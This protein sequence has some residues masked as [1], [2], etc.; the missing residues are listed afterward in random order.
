MKDASA[1]GMPN[2]VKQS[3]QIYI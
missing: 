1:G 2:K 3:F